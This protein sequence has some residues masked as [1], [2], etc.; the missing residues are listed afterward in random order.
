MDETWEYSDKDVTTNQLSIASLA[1]HHLLSVLTCQAA[2]NN[3]TVPATAS[4]TLDLNLKPTDVK[5]SAG[6]EL[7]AEREAVLQCSAFGSR[8]RAVLS[9]TFAGERYSTPLSAGSL[10][11]HQTSTTLT[12]RPRREHHGA[13]VTCTAENPKIPDSAISDVLRLDVQCLCLGLRPQSLLLIFFF[14]FSLFPPPDSPTDIPHLAL[15][16]GSPTL[17]L[18]SIQEGNDVYFDCHVQANP[19]PSRPVAWKRDGVPLSPAK[20]QLILLIP[21]LVVSLAHSD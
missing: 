13:E 20:G 4:L 1:R 6:Q 15:V 19:F 18:N 2:N 5:L 14:P 3:I 21:C 9:W 7:V 17:S 11:E 16:L 12:I 8:P 10:A